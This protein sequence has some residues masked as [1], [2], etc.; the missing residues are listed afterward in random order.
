MTTEWRL[1]VDKG[2]S[3]KTYPKRDHAHALVGVEHAVRDFARYEQ[4]GVVDTS[5]WE[6]WIETRQVSDWTRIDV[7]Q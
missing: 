2:F 6:A 3:K 5:G 4:M 7:L 1:V